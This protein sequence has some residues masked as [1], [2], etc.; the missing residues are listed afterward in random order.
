MA[1]N[2]RV[3]SRRPKTAKDL[4]HELPKA[5]RQRL[6]GKSVDIRDEIHRLE[7]FISAAPR[8][9]RQ[10]RLDRVHVVPPHETEMAAQ[11]SRLPRHLPL[12]QQIAL[13]RTRMLHLAELGIVGVCIAGLAGWLNQFLHIFR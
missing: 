3:A 13:K 6:A 2:K 4:T 10:Q 7:C 12:Q 11:R 8:I 9:S 1:A 5:G